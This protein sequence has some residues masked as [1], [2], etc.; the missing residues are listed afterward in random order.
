MERGEI[1]QAI[2]DLARIKDMRLDKKLSFSEIDDSRFASV[3][4]D[5]DQVRKFLNVDLGIHLENE[6]QFVHKIT[7]YFSFQE[8]A[9]FEQQIVFPRREMRSELVQDL[10]MNARPYLQSVF[11]RGRKNEDVL[12]D[13]HYQI[14][15]D[16]GNEISFQEIDKE[17]FTAAKMIF[18]ELLITLFKI[19]HLIEIR[20]EIIVDL[21]KIKKL[22]SE[23][24]L[25]LKRVL[26]YLQMTETRHGM[27]FIFSLE[28]T[29][30]NID[31]CRQYLSSMMQTKNKAQLLKFKEDKENEIY[32]SGVEDHFILKMLE[33]EAKRQ[34]NPSVPFSFKLFHVS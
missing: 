9:Y 5:W 3:K 24:F 21:Y 34:K 26:S 12:Q 13:K 7:D 8:I 17:I 32:L 31:L 25:N 23:D 15:L 29:R 1:S 2:D 18:I 33:V 14:S 30:S 28:K 10:I 11:M 16:A 6:R 4:I 19:E 22:N 27:E 20:P